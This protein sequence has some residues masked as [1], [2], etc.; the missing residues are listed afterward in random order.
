MPGA[1]EKLERLTLAHPIGA[2]DGFCLLPTLIA[3]DGNK[4]S[5]NTKN[6]RGT[7]DYYLTGQVA[8]LPTLCARDYKSP[9]SAEHWKRKS[10]TRSKPL[11]D[12]LVHTT[13]HRLTA[14]VAE[15]LMGFPLNHTA[16]AL[17]VTRKFRSRRQRRGSP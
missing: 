2:T 1:T 4:N 8:R 16:S 10:G 17:W 3:S 11:P 6:S 13:G 12:T 15:W 9:C 14:T 5:I 7:G